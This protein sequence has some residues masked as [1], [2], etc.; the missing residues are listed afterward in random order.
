MHPVRSVEVFPIRGTGVPNG[1]T[2]LVLS[3]AL[4]RVEVVGEVL[5]EVLF[6]VS[7]QSRQFGDEKA[8]NKPGSP[9]G[10]ASFN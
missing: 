5:A 1:S 10:D 8:P 3:P 7:P 6:G 4:S 9:T 2:E